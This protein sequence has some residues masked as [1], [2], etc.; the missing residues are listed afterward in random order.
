MS[1]EARMCGFQSATNEAVF[2]QTDIAAM[3]KA[4]HGACDALAFAFLME[5]TVDSETRELLARSILEAARV[6]ERNPGR[7]SALALRRLPPRE[8]QWNEVPH[9]PPVL[10]LPVKRKC[11][12]LR[13]NDRKLV[14]A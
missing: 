5:G 12:A 10:G 6:G 7:L 3:R 13:L 11:A 8:A 4:L 2:D 1:G 14:G 9:Q